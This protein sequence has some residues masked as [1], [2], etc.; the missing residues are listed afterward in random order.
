MTEDHKMKP[1]YNDPQVNHEYNPRGTQLENTYGQ[2]SYLPTNYDYS[3]KTY[4]DSFYDEYDS[5]GAGSFLFGALVGGVIGAAAALFLA[6]KSGSEMR[7]DFSSQATQFKDKSIEISAVAKEKATEFSSVAKEKTEGLSKT[8][9]EQSGLL[10][11]KVK[12]MASKTSVPMD[13]GTAS[14]EGEEAIDFIDTA[15]SKVEDTLEKGKQ[16]VK[17]TAD[18]LKTQ[19]SKDAK[20][21][22]N[23]SLKSQSTGNSNVTYDNSENVGKDKI[24]NQNYV[25]EVEDKNKK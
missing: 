9:Q 19:V 6:P 22:N 24:T 14:S 7:N 21:T 12:S 11:D 5:S 3:R 1:N 18:T 4:T 17:S 23:N 10:V 8:F 25:S 20:D 2:P 16:K 15:V 13:D